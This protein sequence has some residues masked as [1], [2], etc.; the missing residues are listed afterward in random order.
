MNAGKWLS[1]S[2]LSSAI[3]VS[4]SMTSADGSVIDYPVF[5]TVDILGVPVSRTTIPAA[6]AA[7]FSAIRSG[8]SQ[9]VCVRDVHGIM[10]AVE[11]PEM[12]EIQR[13]AA[14]VT[15]D[16]MPLV[17]V[18]RRRGYN[19]I[20]RVCGADLMEAVCAASQAPGFKHFF[21][22]GKEGVAE[23]LIERLR[24]RYPGLQVAGHYC[25]PFRSLTTAED[26]AATAMIRASGADIVWVGI[27]TP[28]QEYWM[29]DHVS[30][31]PGVTLLGVGA[32]FDFHAGIIKRAPV[33]MRR[34]SLEWLHRLGSEPRRLWRRYLIMV[35]HVLREKSSETR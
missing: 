23:L 20:E 13:R 34:L 29:R 11:H 30:Q 35:W 8:K 32:A 2:P 31:L 33:I 9:Y 14:I 25:P 28:K 10:H 3:K 1:S 26:K 7:I 18:A 12:M 17:I 27:S 15:P 5:P 16:G 21:Y 4:V 24:A 6:V 22:G 19:D